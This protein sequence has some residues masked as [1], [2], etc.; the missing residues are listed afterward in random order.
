MEHT[1]FIHWLIK[2]KKIKFPA[3]WNKDIIL[4]WCNEEAIRI[5]PICHKLDVCYD[6]LMTAIQEN[7][8]LYVLIEKWQE[9]KI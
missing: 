1:Q 7:R 3:N 6:H 4:K 2:G 8:L 5:C 9:Y